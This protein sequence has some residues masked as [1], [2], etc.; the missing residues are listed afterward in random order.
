MIETLNTSNLT[1]KE[2][3]K[4][5]VLTSTGQDGGNR[6]LH[7]KKAQ[8]IAILLR[9]LNV[10]ADYLK[11]SLATLEGACEE[12]RSSRMFLKLLEAV[13]K[14][15]NHMNVGTNRGDAHTFKLDTLLKLADVKGADW[16]TTL[17]HFVVQEIIQAE[18]SRLRNS[19]TTENTNAEAKCRKL[20][21]QVV[22]K[23]SSELMKR[24]ESCDNGC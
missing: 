18:G 14:T 7:S 24:E 4:M 13:L 21:L 15:G 6:V 17:L 11:K 16:K 3:N 23:L 8:N 22:S 5:Q 1:P 10:I 2:V 12:L 20:G 19:N 9:A